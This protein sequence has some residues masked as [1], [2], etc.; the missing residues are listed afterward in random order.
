VLAL[1]L[2]DGGNGAQE[3]RAGEHHGFSLWHD[4]SCCKKGAALILAKHR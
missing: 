1:L 2:L 3:E 4:S